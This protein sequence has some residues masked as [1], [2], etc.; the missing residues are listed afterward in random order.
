[1]SQ[2]IFFVAT[3]IAVGIAVSAISVA[4]KGLSFAMNQKTEL[5]A[6]QVSTVI[7]IVD[8]D[9]NADKNLLW[10]YV[11]NL[12]STTLD[13]NKFD[14][15]VNGRYVGACN[16]TD[17][18]CSDESGDFLLTPNELMEVNVRMPITS[19]SY[20]IRAVTQYGTYADYEVVVG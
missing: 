18:N 4:L 2:I 7:K 8:G 5:S 12:G 15:F 3:L 9:A 14:I 17:V 1:M 13:V 19:S 11:E 16:T 10:F 20:R 6:A